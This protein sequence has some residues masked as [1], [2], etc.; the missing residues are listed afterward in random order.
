MDI[1]TSLRKRNTIRTLVTN[2]V[3]EAKELLNNSKLDIDLLEELL[4]KIKQKECQLKEINNQV[5]KLIDVSSI[6]TEMLD[7]EE[8]N[9]K[10]SK[11]IRKI[12]RK[13][14]PNI[15]KNPESQRE[16]ESKGRGFNVKLPKLTIE[17]F[18]G[19]PQEWTEFWN[20]FET[21]IHE[22]NVLSEVEKFSYLKMYLRGK[23]LN[24]VSWFKLSSENY[25]NRI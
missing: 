16:I 5:E 14:K 4:M 10:I 17:K 1:E 18:T 15:V 25:D 7:S 24:V 21:T 20:S 11:C 9:D 12:N 19:N 22:N 23:A 2:I 13:L 8:F 6:E 3:Q